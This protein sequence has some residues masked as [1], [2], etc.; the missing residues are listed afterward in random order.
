VGAVPE[1]WQRARRWFRLRLLVI[2]AL[3][4]GAVV[5]VLLVPPLP[6]DPTYHD[7]ADKRPLLGVPHCCNVVS[8]VPF[9]VVGALGLWFV[10][11]RPGAF[12]DPA[13]RWP[14]AVFFV[15]VALTA[16][17][18]SYY[19]LDP[20]NDRLLWDRLPMAV[21]FMALFSSVVAERVHLRAGLWLMPLLV[22][23][24]VA[25]VLYWHRTEQEGHGDLRFYYLVQF[26]PL[27][28]LP[29]LLLFFPARYTG[30]SYLVG[31]LGWYVLAKVLEDPFDAPVY[32]HTGVSGHTLKHL[33]AALAALWILE[34]L[35]HRRPVSAPR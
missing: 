10:L 20:N 14:Y 4:V 9:L 21:A 11:R 6:Q 35:R 28:V 1:D 22:A 2:A 31:A 12:L 19:H 26:Y 33:S 16:V 3:G 23:A 30:T 27:L 15:G 18:S 8:N 34:M 5:L 17:G 7:F 24:G 32:S 13:E 29:I 25:S